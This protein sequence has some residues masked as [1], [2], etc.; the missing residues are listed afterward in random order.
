MKKIE[1][2]IADSNDNDNG[3]SY[4][5]YVEVLEQIILFRKQLVLVAQQFS[6]IESKI[7]MVTK[8]N[9]RVLLH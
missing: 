5:D 1:N 9:A 3:P 8:A 7:D 2:G 6:R 4:K